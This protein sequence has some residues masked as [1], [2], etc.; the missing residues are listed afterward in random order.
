MPFCLIKRKRTEMKTK[1]NVLFICAINSLVE[2]EGRYPH[3][4]FGYMAAVLR[5]KLPEIDFNIRIIQDKY[6]RNILDF[7]PDIV[8]IS[9]VSQNFNIAMDVGDICRSLNIPYVMGGIHITTLPET[10]PKEALAG[11]VGEGDFTFSEIVSAYFK[12]D[13][14]INKLKHIHG[15]VYW[16]DDILIKTAPRAP[17]TSLDVLP[18]PE[19]ELL[20]I[21]KHTY[22]FTSRGCPYKCSFCASTLFWDKLTWFSA[23]YVV[24]EIKYLY[25]EYQVEMISFFDD[26]FIANIPRMKIIIELLRK[27]GL[28]EKIKYTCSCRANL[29]KEQTVD[30]LVEMGVVSVGLGLESGNDK[31]LKFLKGGGISIEHNY[32]AVELLK[33]KGIAVNASFVIG[34]PQETR[35]QIMDTYNFI[36]KSNMDLFDVYLLTPYPGT[37]IWNYACER[38]IVQNDMKDWNVFDVNAYRKTNSDLVLLSETLS[39]QEIVALYKKFRRLRFIRNFAKVLAHPLKRD[40][41]V[42]GYRM[43]REHVCLFF[44]KWTAVK[45]H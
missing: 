7:K 21:N 40:L 43:V 17:L 35:E 10:L 6:E 33:N 8:G 18:L 3:L 9:A 29:V 11:V 4:G 16:H 23:E 42:I 14:S 22:M 32:R 34:A 27:E 12:D 37:P 31:I 2:V 36:K 24:E 15:I 5:N 38:G 1:I 13:F 44:S 28:L 30:L 20:S 45:N 39:R 26:L 19:R 41:L 25:N